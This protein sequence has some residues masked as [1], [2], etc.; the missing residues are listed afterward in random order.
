VY[1]KEKKR[2]REVNLEST[3]FGYIC[4]SIE[5]MGKNEKVLVFCIWT[6]EI[7]ILLDCFEEREISALRFDGKMSREQREL[8]IYNFNNTDV[9][10]LVIQI[11]TGGV[12]LN[13]QVATNIFITSPTWNPCSELQAI[14]RAHR[15]GQER[16]VNCVRLVIEN[17]VEDRILAI[18]DNKLRLIADCF[19]DEGLF[20]K[21][22][23]VCKRGDVL[24]LF[25]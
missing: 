20:G 23:G 8:A 18:Q 10:V 1:F 14:A 5:K 19:G 15:L 22:G 24:R 4:D 2:K 9:R 25:E 3:K 7:E 21:M 16:V 6:A 11:N 13:L 12:G 17:T